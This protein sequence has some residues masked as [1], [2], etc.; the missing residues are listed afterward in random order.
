MGKPYHFHQCMWHAGAWAIIMGVS[1]HSLTLKGVASHENKF[2]QRRHSRDVGGRCQ[3]A[4]PPPLDSGL[5]RNDGG[6]AALH[7]HPRMWP[8]GAWVII[9][10]IASNQRRHSRESGN[11]EFRER[12]R[13]LRSRPQPTPLDSGLRWNDGGEAALHLHPRMWPGG[14]WVIIMKIASNQHRH[15]RE[16]GNPGFRDVG[17]RCEVAHNPAPGFRPTPE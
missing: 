11:P 12:R 1:G 17:G 8:G 7:F 9:M 6:E 14:A 3:V 2:S 5:R 13:S 15:S 16:S 4:Y 10:K